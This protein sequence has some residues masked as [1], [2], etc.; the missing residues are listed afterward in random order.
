[1]IFKSDMKANPSGILNHFHIFLSV[2]LIIPTFQISLIGAS[3][4]F[5]C[6]EMFQHFV[7]LI[8]GKCLHFHA[9]ILILLFSI[10]CDRQDSQLD[11]PHEISQEYKL[12]CDHAYWNSFCL[13]LSVSNMNMEGIHSILV[14]IPSLSLTLNASCWCS[15]N[16]NK[17]VMTYGSRPTLPL[18]GWKNCTSSVCLKKNE[19]VSCD[20]GRLDITQWTQTMKALYLCNVKS[21]LATI[22]VQRNA[23]NNV[24]IVS[25]VRGPANS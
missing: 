25:V 11:A 9:W 12:W 24:S 4:I 5:V 17:G 15:E 2:I 13:L 22:Y 23:Q 3:L 6:G 7:R 14:S 19:K 16:L 10:T 21:C 20:K 1:M 8:F 18:Q